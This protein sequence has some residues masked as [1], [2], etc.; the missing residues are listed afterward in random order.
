[1]GT[2]LY[3]APEIMRGA[4][5]AKPAADIF[6]FGIIAYEVITGQLPSEIPPIMMRLEPHRRWYTSLAARSP[7]L[8]ELLVRLIEQC[9]DAA[10]ENRPAAAALATALRE[11]IRGLHPDRP[12]AEIDGD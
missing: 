1:M 7:K 10:P 8:P 12:V 9:L 11:A 5:L 2:P 6:G 4:K 3:M